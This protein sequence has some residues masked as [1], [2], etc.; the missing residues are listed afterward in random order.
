[1]QLERGTGQDQSW[2]VTVLFFSPSLPCRSG[3][4][5]DDQSFL[6]GHQCVKARFPGPGKSSFFP[7]PHAWRRYKRGVIS[8]GLWFEGVWG[9]S[10][11]DFLSSLISL[12]TVTAFSSRRTGFPALSGRCQRGREGVCWGICECMLR[13]AGIL[14]QFQMPIVSRSR[15]VALVA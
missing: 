5:C 14:E 10:L 8:R 6:F 9:Y 4:F 2:R 3:L 13:E 15:M 11:G 1:M 12:H 7:S